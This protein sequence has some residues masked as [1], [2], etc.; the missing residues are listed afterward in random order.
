MP[1]PGWAGTHAPSL[2]ESLRQSTPHE[3]FAKSGV[4]FARLIMRPVLA[5]RREFWLPTIW[6][7]LVLLLMGAATIV[8]VARNLH[9]FLAINEPVGARVL[10][11]EGWLRQPQLDEAAAVFRS[12]RYERILTT[13]GPIHYWPDSHGPATF[14]ERAADYLKRRLPDA[15]ITA[16]PA[17]DLMRNRTFLTAVVVREWAKRS[18]LNFEALDVF[19]AGAHARRSRIL[20]RSAFGPK[21]KV[22]VFAVKSPDYDADAWWRTSHGAEEVVQQAIALL[23]VQCCFWPPS[24]DSP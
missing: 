23:W 5:R 11:I 14:A 1:P 3:S 9:S 10:V 18:G 19:S 22:G 15:S 16:V 4:A 2:W 8:F 20:Y 6:G 12:G 21:I 24:P 7:W 13:G 17:P